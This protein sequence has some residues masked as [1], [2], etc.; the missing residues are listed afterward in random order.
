MSAT[1]IGA[2]NPA[3]P[4]RRNDATVIAS[5]AGQSVWSP[6]LNPSHTKVV[7]V[8]ASPI[9]IGAFNGA[10]HIVIADIT[11]HHRHT[12]TTGNEDSDP[13][14]SPRG[15]E[16]A[17]IR[18]G[19]IWLMSPNGRHQLRISAAI[20]AVHSISW[21]PNGNQIAADSGDPGRIAII[22]LRTNSFRWL[23]PPGKAQDDPSWS[24]DGRFLVY[25]QL[26]ANALFISN[27]IG[28]AHQLTV[29]N[30]HCS[31]DIEPTW[32]PDGGTIAFVRNT[33]GTQQIYVVPSSGGPVREVTHGSVQHALPRW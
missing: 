22:D 25:T 23:T 11:G 32:S 33:G 6:A 16:I 24:P 18:D 21:A 2:R 30:G 3:W 17:F 13:V 14:W 5:R 12:I 19:S 8:S 29:C 9:Q 20:S 28:V 31:E 10:G 1:E 26:G 15:N 7:Y 4:S 27:L